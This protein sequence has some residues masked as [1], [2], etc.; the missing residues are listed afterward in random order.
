MDHDYRGRGYVE[1]GQQLVSSL[2]QLQSAHV[3]Y[4]AKLIEFATSAGYELTWG[5]TLL[6]T[7]LNIVAA[8][9]SFPWTRSVESVVSSLPTEF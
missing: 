7:S 2:R 1:N 5:E 3:R 6:S 9:S 4:T 8:S